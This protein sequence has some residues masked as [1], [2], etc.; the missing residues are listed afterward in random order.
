MSRRRAPTP[1][2]SNC[3]SIASGLLQSVGDMRLAILVCAVLAAVTVAGLLAGAALAIFAV[4]AALLV[5]ALVW[6]LSRGLE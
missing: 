4:C 5:A 2:R 3:A 6:V 1:R